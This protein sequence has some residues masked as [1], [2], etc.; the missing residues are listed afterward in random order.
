MWKEG[1]IQDRNVHPL[2]G[3]LVQTPDGELGVFPLDSGHAIGCWQVRAAC[4]ARSMA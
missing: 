3:K 1:G 2:Q 4:S